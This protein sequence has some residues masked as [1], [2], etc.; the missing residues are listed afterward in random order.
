M[1]IAASILQNPE[2]LEKSYEAAQHSEGV[3]QK[4]LDIYLDSISAR[5]QKLQNHLQELAAVNV[6]TEWIKDMVSLFDKLI[7]LVTNLTSKFGGLNVVI[8]GVVGTLLGTT[9]NGKGT[10]TLMPPFSQQ[11]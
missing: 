10:P 1:N 3:G 4:E 11:I 8:G 6:K 5:I 2:L 7:Q 9:G